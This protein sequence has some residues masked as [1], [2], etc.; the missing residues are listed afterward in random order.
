MTSQVSFAFGL[1]YDVDVIVTVPVAFAVIVPL[2]STVATFVSL[3]VQATDFQFAF[4]GN[5]VTVN[6]SVSPILKVVIKLSVLKE[7]E[8]K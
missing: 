5:T 7:N 4:V 1:S 8:K 3:E 6:V 2:Q